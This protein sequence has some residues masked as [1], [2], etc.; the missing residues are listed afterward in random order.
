[1]SIFPDQAQM[2]SS[3]VKSSE[4]QID[5][6]RKLAFQEVLS[7]A[8]DSAQAIHDM[9][10][11]AKSF[12]QKVSLSYICRK[13]G[14]NSKGFLS[15]VMKGRRQIGQKYWPKLAEIFQL[16]P[17]YREIFFLLL[18]IDAEKDQKQLQLLR[19]EL[20]I[21]RK[22]ANYS[23]R[24]LSKKLR[25]MFFA[26][27]VFCAFGLFKNQP[28]REDLRSYFGVQRGLELDVALN[29]LLSTDLIER[30]E[31]HSFRIKNHNIRFSDS[32]DSFSHLDFLKESIEDARRSVEQWKDRRQ[33]SIFSSYIIS[34]K[35]QHYQKVVDKL[36]RD[37]LEIQSGLES[38]D[39]D[40]LVR[41]NIQ[42]YPT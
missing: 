40:L 17:T 8:N 34:V 5:Q 31:D 12:D 15:D 18:S 38:E 32:E 26:F 35:R 41:F 2:Q 24:I 1:M 14:L 13:L 7:S 36:R 30:L 39:A 3:S 23:E 10:Q 6:D 28:S 22:A 33:E 42:V 19:E 29:I 21:K 9:V 25:G 11:I 16:D 4:Q 20:A 37:L 27:D